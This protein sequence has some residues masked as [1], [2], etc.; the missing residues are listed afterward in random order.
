ML[1]PVLVAAPAKP[2]V[3]TAEI[4]AQ[5]VAADFFD[6]DVVLDRL[7][8]AATAHLD[9]WTG[10][11]GRCLINQQWRQDFWYWPTC[12][13][14]KLP[15]PDVS[16]VEIAY[17]DA[18]NVKQIVDSSLYDLLQDIDGSNVWFK[19]AFTYPTIYYN[20]RDGL[21]I[22]MTAGYG[23][24]SSAVPEAIRHA[25]MMLATHWYGNR[26]AVEDGRNNAPLEVPLGVSMLIEPYRRQSL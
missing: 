6:D 9:G 17:Y 25:I 23:A 11:L 24:D 13:Y 8:A 2:V 12:R 16:V 18:E 3:T 4:K 7:V 5:V 21:Q 14:I 19:D 26:S 10:I 20:R 15:F 1:R 22:T